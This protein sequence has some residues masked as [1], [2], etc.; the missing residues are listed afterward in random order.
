M[1]ILLL[2]GTFVLAIG[3]VLT[4]AFLWIYLGHYREIDVKFK[5]SS[6]SG[7]RYFYKG[8]NCF[9]KLLLKVIRV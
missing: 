1:I 4:I 3:L 2:I 8:F 7:R 6:F 9:H 5:T